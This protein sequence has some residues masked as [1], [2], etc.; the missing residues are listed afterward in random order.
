MKVFISQ[1]MKDK[2]LSEIK[3]VKRKIKKLLAEKFREP[4]TLIDQLFN[5]TPIDNQPT[6]VPFS[7]EGFERLPL[8][9]LGRSIAHMAEADL[10]V[11]AK[12]WQNARGCRIEYEVA[13]AYKK[14]ILVL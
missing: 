5:I 12:G 9:Y 14:T 10:V 7:D 13:R 4:I 11:M 8:Y 6:T 1:P 2:S 3:K